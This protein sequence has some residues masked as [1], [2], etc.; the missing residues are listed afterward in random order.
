M[1]KLVNYLNRLNQVELSGIRRLEDGA[2]IPLD[3]LNSDYQR[4]LAWVDE[5]NTPLP[6]DELSQ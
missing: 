1:Y 2:L 6:A 4:Y 3:L 5:G